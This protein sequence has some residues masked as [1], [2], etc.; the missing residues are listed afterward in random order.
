MNW[1]RPVTDGTPGNE[2]SARSRSLVDDVDD[3]DAVPLGNDDYDYDYDEWC[4]V[5]SRRRTRTSASHC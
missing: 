2:S 4:R 1:W 5:S 3:D